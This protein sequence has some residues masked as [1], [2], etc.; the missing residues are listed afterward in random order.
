M[1]LDLNFAAVTSA[2]PPSGFVTAPAKPSR[3]LNLSATDLSRT[4]N[5]AICCSAS[6]QADF[7]ASLASQTFVS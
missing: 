4:V 5:A 2:G 7:A 1:D 6:A 3:L